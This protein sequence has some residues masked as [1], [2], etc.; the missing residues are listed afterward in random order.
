MLQLDA[1]T[2]AYV[3]LARRCDQAMGKFGVDAPISR[4]IGIGQRLAF[5]LVAKAHVVELGGLRRQ[6]DFGTAQTLAVGQ[7]RKGH[8]AELIGACHR[9]DVAVAVVAI[10]DSGEGSPWQEIHQLGEQGWHSPKPVD[11]FHSV[12]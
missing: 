1:E 11:T 10:D 4:L 3:E 9:L 7:L 6:T 5:D 8:H 2:V 12:V